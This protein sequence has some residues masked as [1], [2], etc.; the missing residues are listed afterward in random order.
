MD[1]RVL[2]RVM[3]IGMAV[4]MILAGLSIIPEEQ[5]MLL[6][7][8]QQC[9]VLV[10]GAMA[11]T[12]AGCA[13]TGKWPRTTRLTTVLLA[14]GWALL[15]GSWIWFREEPR[16]MAMLMLFVAHFCFSLLATRSRFWHTTHAALALFAGTLT[17]DFWLVHGL[18]HMPYFWFLSL[19]FAVG[20]LPFFVYFL[21]RRQAVML[22]LLPFSML[23][24]M[25]ALI[26]HQL[27]DSLWAAVCLTIGTVAAG[28]FI[29][30]RIRTFLRQPVPI[31]SS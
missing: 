27:Q 12:G 2:G 18:W 21:Y 20:Y 6:S 13:Y 24:V 5:W 1:W 8:L 17:L 9:T 25:I 3:F 30:Y 26:F 23:S 10:A 28:S 11:G 14:D 19:A 29:F 15:A 31:A 16:L 7:T 4:L 22:Y